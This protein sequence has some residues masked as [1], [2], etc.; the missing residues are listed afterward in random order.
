LD[1]SIGLFVL[2]Q[3]GFIRGVGGNLIHP[4]FVP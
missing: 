2:W 3:L 1:D 4:L